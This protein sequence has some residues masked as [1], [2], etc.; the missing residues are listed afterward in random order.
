M[1][2]QK[3]EAYIAVWGTLAAFG[4]YY[5]MYAFRKPFAAAQFSDLALWGFDYKV[6]LVVSQLFG[7]LL[8][9]FIGV[10]VI[11][12]LEARH[13]IPAL[14]LLLAWAEAALIGFAVVPVAWS[15]LF[16]FLNGI[17]LGMVFGVVFSFLEGRRLTE[18]MSLGLGIS[19]IFASG[20]VKYI[21]KVLLDD[22]HISP[23]WMPA[24]TGLL[25]VPLLAV[26]TYM[27]LRLPPPSPADIAARSVRLPMTGAQRTALFRRYA[28]GLV[29]LV[30]TYILLTILRDIR[31]NFA[32]EIWSALGYSGQSGVLAQS[33]LGV[34][35]LILG[36]VGALSLLRN[37]GLAFR[38][39]LLAISAGGLLLGGATW[40]FEQ[41]QL[42][43]LTW[44]ILAGFGLFIGYTLFQGILFERMLAHY[45]ETGNVGFLMYLAD[46]FGYL[47]SA[48]VMLWKNTGSTGAM[49]WL[50]FFT[51]VSYVIAGLSVLFSLAAMVYFFQKNPKT[52][53]QTELTLQTTP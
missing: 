46:A 16:L 32:V 7:Y 19:I 26:S 5:S 9:K 41:G 20:S 49:N 42:S 40:L 47:G 44:M 39:T 11:S 12:E 28:P 33:E 38:V 23:F 17:P 30:L 27:L 35:L 2:R 29:L 37:N 10:K 50:G 13:R 43:P 24:L 21:G 3:S 34:S 31:D 36:F 8:S 48:G 51:T 25:F 18:L 4:A 14:L 53:E 45:R 22:Y 1:K 6:V 15:P 52:A